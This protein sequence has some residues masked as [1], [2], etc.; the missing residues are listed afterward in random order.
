MRTRALFS[1]IVFILLPIALFAQE[2]IIN[3]GSE[4]HSFDLAEVHGI[5]FSANHSFELGNSGVYV[6]MVWIPA[7]TFMMGATEDEPD[8]WDCEHP[9]H[10]VTLSE[11]FWMG[12]YE[13]TQEQ[14]EAIMGDWDFHFDDCPNR[15]ADMIAWNDIVDGFL[16]LLDDEW[17][18]PTAAEW[19]YACRAGVN[20][21]WFW[22]GSDYDQLDQ[23]E[24]FV[25]NSGNETHEVGQKLPNPWGLY[26]MNGNVWEW[27]SDWYDEDYYEECYPSVIDPQGPEDGTTHVCQPGGYLSVAWGC[28]AAHFRGYSPSNVHSSIGFRLVRDSR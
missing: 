14:W 2:M 25:D 19:E 15:P 13:V 6:E 28:R 17:R 12:K 18:L 1:F 7:G 9:Q 26:D 10:E 27:C 3:T 11:G 23:Y 20:D 8:T 4:T 24:W 5:S 22:W 21:E 16:P